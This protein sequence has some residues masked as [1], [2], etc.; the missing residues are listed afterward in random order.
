MYMTKTRLLYLGG[1][2]YCMK[3]LRRYMLLRNYPV[4]TQIFEIESRKKRV[5]L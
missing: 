4:S 5:S 3:V 2:F 1:P